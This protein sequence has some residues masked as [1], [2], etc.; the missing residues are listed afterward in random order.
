MLAH[1]VFNNGTPLTEEQMRSKVPSIFGDTA[2]ESRS[3][4]F[5]PIPT[6]EV[7]RALAGE[8]FFPVSV[9][10]QGS[11][12]V[13]R[14]PFSK[15]LIRLRRFDNAEKL[16]VNDTIAEFVLRNANDGTSPWDIMGG[17][18]R[19]A[20]LNGGIVSKGNLEHFKVRHIL[21]DPNPRAIVDKVI[22]GTYNIL[23][24]VDLVLE[25][26]RL[27]SQVTLD[28]HQM[29][30]FA[31]KA[32]NFIFAD[33]DGVPRTSVKPEQLLV[34][35][36][37]Q[38]TGNDLWSVFNVVQEWAMRGGIESSSVTETERFGRVETRSRTHPIN[39][40]DRSLKMNKGLYELA[41]TEY[42]ELVA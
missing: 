3:V 23:R 33:I 39:A 24:N 10:Q 29:F 26:P 31:H 41:Q 21:N 5:K 11:R 16:Q 38:D 36:R 28:E 9:Q 8:G 12:K 34:R 30:Q 7:L 22:E 37:V 18:F 27:W 15:H 35:R 4:K 20:C 17:L 2:H 14:L 1:A 13:D 25:A 42:Q 40:I 6:I 19:I 32:W